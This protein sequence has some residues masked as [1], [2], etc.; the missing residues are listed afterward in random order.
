MILRDLPSCP[1]CN[2]PAEDIYMGGVF[3]VCS[4]TG[5]NISTEK[6]EDLIAASEAWRYT[7]M[8]YLKPVPE[9]EDSKDG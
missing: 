9:S 2:S 3:I 5:C 1:A 7:C 8:F 4:R 6:E